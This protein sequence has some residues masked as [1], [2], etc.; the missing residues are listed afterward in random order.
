MQSMYKSSKAL[1]V[2][3][4]RRIRGALNRS[5]DSDDHPLQELSASDIEAEIKVHQTELELTESKIDKVE[6]E[7]KKKSIRLL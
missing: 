6:S 3:L 2:D 1:M 4:R 5:D 7:L